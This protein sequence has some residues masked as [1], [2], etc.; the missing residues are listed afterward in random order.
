MSIN[1]ILHVGLPKCGSSA[2][3]Q[4]LSLHPVLQKNSG[5]RYLYAAITADG[6]MLQGD[7]LRQQLPARGQSYIASTS[8]KELAELGPA[9]LAILKA[10]LGRI[11]KADDTLI[12]SNEGWSNH[13]GFFQQERLLESLGLNCHVV[14]YVRPQLAWL[15]SGWWQWGA[16]ENKPLEQWVNRKIDWYRVVEGWRNTSG[17][18]KVTVRLLPKDIVTDFSRVIGA[19]PPPHLG[20]T[21]VSLPG[22]VLRVLQRHRELRPDAHSPEIEFVLS[23]HL[24]MEKGKT[25]WVLPPELI[26]RV[27]KQ[28]HDSNK[29]LMDCLDDEQKLLMQND[30]AW[31]SAE[32]Y[33]DRMVEPCQPQE[34]NAV[35]L[36]GLVAASFEALRNL[37]RQYRAL[38][39]DRADNS[40]WGRISRWFKGRRG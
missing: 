39:A 15:N 31:W 6:L 34:P 22:S 37:D 13:F 23:R 24:K 36:D 14:L 3:Q 25:P 28:T 12:L 29:R 20:E 10:M 2:I 17:V 4:A 9:R 40:Y 1:C 8:W 7:S 38:L 5:G 30:P 27:L 18:E 26:E 19:V 32:Y 21:N 33:A 35:E 11:L 16:W